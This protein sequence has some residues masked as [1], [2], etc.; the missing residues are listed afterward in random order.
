M[1]GEHGIFGHI[2]KLGVPVY[3]ENSHP[4]GAD[5]TEPEHKSVRSV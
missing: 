3:P 5:S 2:A 1:T 4:I